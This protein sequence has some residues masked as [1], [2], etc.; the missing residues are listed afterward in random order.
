[1]VSAADTGG[2]GGP[3]W[4]SIDTSSGTHVREVP[5][6]DFFGTGTGAALDPPVPAAAGAGALEPPTEAE[7]EMLA[8]GVTPPRFATDLRPGPGQVVHSDDGDPKMRAALTEGGEHGR[9]P[10]RPDDVPVSDRGESAPDTVDRPAEEPGAEDTNA[11]DIPA[12][13]S[14]GGEG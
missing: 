11:V 5:G 7:Q 6:D 9:P 12:A 3:A 2:A 4:P 10:Q 14:E 1:A 13:P 8:T